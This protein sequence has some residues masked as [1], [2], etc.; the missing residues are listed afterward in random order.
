MNFSV[1]PPCSHLKVVKER[2]Q[3]VLLQ[4]KESGIL[5][6][7]DRIEQKTPPSQTSALLRSVPAPIMRAKLV[8][9]LD[10]G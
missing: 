9:S 5:G 1:R 7:S 4:A 6:G 10:I 3:V 2:Q 8:A